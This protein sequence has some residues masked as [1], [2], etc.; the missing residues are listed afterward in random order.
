MRCRGEWIEFQL[1]ADAHTY[2]TSARS[3]VRR[4]D[5]DSALRLPTGTE[6]WLRLD[7]EVT[8]GGSVGLW[9]IAFDHRGQPT[10]HKVRLRTGAAALQVATGPD[11]RAVTVAVRLSGTGKLRLGTLHI[12]DVPPVVEA[13]QPAARREVET[14][15]DGQFRRP[16][17][18]FDPAGY[19]PYA[20]RHH[21]YYDGREPSWY[22]GIASRV[23]DRPRVLEIGC[24]PGLLLEQL[25]A[26]DSRRPVCGLE[27]DPVFVE[28]CR[29]KGLPVVA[30]DLNQPFPFLPSRS[31]DAIIAHQSIDFLTPIA[32]RSCLREC[33]RVLAPGGRLRAKSRRQGQATGEV[34][35]TVALT[36]ALLTEALEEAG[37][38]DVKVRTPDV[39]IAVDALAPALGPG[40]WPCRD[41][42][43]FSGLPVRP[44]G[45]ARAPLAP[46]AGETV[47]DDRSRRDL[48]L[49]TDGEKRAVRVDGKRVGYF[50]G[51]SGPAIERA[52][53]RAVEEES[54]S[55]RREPDE[56]VLCGG[57]GWDDGGV[58]AGSV[59]LVDGCYRMYFSGR[60]PSGTWR[61]VGIADSDDGV[62]WHKRAEPVLRL[63]DHPE[64][65]HLALADVV[66]GSD[67]TWRMHCEGW[68]GEGWTVVQATSTDGLAW[69][70]AEVVLDPGA[71]DWAG[72]HVANPK[73]L[74]LAPGQWLLGFNG[75]GAQLRFQLGLARSTDGRSWSP[76]EVGPVLCT[77]G[78][79]RVE[80]MFATA[81]AWA[82]GSQETFFFA[83]ATK[84]TTTSSD[85]RVARADPDAC[86][87][88]PPWTTRR[89]GLYRI[90]GGHLM[91]G[92]GA[93]APEDRLAREVALEGR[94]AQVLVRQRVVGRG[95]ELTIRAVGTV[96]ALQSDGGA[97]IGEEA[98][99]PAAAGEDVAAAMVR[100]HRAG[101]PDAELELVVWHGDRVAGRRQLPID[102]PVERMAI[103]LG[104]PPGAPPMVVEAVDVWTADLREVEP[105][106]DAL[107]EVPAASEP[108]EALSQRK[109]PP[110]RVLAASRLHDLA[111][112]GPQRAPGWF[113]PLVRPARMAD[114]YD[115]RG[116][117]R[118][119]QLE[120]HWQSGRLVG[121]DLRGASSLPPAVHEWLARRQVI[122]LVDAGSPLAAKL[123]GPVIVDGQLD[124]AAW[125]TWLGGGP[126]RY[127]LLD[128][129]D[130]ASLALANRLPERWMIASRGDA[131]C[132][133]AAAEAVRTGIPAAAAPLMR[134]E[135]LRFLIESV[136]RARWSALLAPDSLRFPLL[137]A[138]AGDCAEQGFEIVAPDALPAGEFEDAKQ[139]WKSYGVRS[140]YRDKKPWAGVLVQL[141]RDLGARGV[142]EFGCNVGRNL[143]AIAERC[144]GVEVCGIDINQEAVEFGR[145]KT[146]LD[147]RV[148]DERGLE[149]FADGAFDLVFCVSVLDHISDIGEV[150]RQ[151][152]RVAG[153][154]LF[155]MEVRLPVEGRVVKN[156]EHST[157]AV[158]P[159]T[160]A[161]YSWHIEKHLDGPRVRRLEV[162][163]CYLHAGS[164]GP[165]YATY[166]AELGPP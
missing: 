102:G 117:Y 104:V 8:G 115:E 163:P 9:V 144:P 120:L 47:W 17:L 57:L 146:S 130:P 134:S 140:W 94:D 153:R 23:A 133:A 44:W 40:S 165:Y 2:V 128:S 141:V 96:V 22:A 93:A 53:M 142:L 148:A 74:E 48:A 49:L 19:R 76:L 28:R 3:G 79:Y 67:G 37:F 35:R 157:G 36:P 158:R 10:P 55:W 20:P 65:K 46:G 100:I 123:A 127:A 43:V 66:R 124:A 73:A 4:P 77:A 33:A 166:L 118:A 106:A 56:P 60:D 84:T 42:E 113:F 152:V 105:P 132:W 41:L 111:A 1:E 145:E 98:I 21:A 62:R 34:T 129:A 137:P 11:H 58:A 26:D 149:A 25:R 81:E 64:L 154:H 32:L 135:N 15:P 162:V 101:L 86:W 92:P 143:H 29:A 12:G 5:D 91:A 122:A 138:T 114:G 71:I 82:D 121:V 88:G 75:A 18:F 155:L 78:D 14:G 164:L 107:W 112:V 125:A 136:Q 52:I 131:R 7:C 13:V 61:G 30:H 103:D 83:A 90:S 59:L 72:R 147:L 139:F 126:H 63:E 31:F 45:S 69:S 54:G 116:A 95:G 16:A 68:R 109:P 50:T 24:G 108:I 150:C 27:R 151:L 99:A 80:S 85:V 159:S 6:H 119:D 161:S 156:F 70:R 51:Y 39:S 87:V 110:G 97:A 38:T 160:G 89:P